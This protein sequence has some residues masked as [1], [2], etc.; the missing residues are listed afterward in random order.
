[1]V[2]SCLD[3]SRPLHC[4][5]AVHSLLAFHPSKEEKGRFRLVFST[6]FRFKVRAMG[7]L[8][9]LLSAS[10]MLSPVQRESRFMANDVLSATQFVPTPFEHTPYQSTPPLKGPHL[11]SP[12]SSSPSNEVNPHPFNAPLVTPDYVT[13]SSGPSEPDRSSATRSP[14]PPF[15]PN[16][17]YGTYS[18]PNQGNPPGYQSSTREHGQSLR[19]S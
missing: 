7:L 10:A 17:I 19:S 8:T 6:W 15:S 5:A 16:T 12:N 14:P 2:A 4:R 13:Q 3:H 1:M 9:H 11:Y 18:T